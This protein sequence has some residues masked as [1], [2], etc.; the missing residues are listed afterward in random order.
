MILAGPSD[1]LILVLVGFFEPVDSDK[2]GKLGEVVKA[3]SSGFSIKELAWS[4]GSKVTGLTACLV[5][6]AGSGSTIVADSG[7]KAD[8]GGS[9]PFS[10][11]SSM[12]VRHFRKVVCVMM[13]LVE[14][15]QTCNEKDSPIS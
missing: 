12:Q 6:G 4:V 8:G 13:E 7:D 14:M 15:E 1:A 5:F 10:I 11:A 2:L 9:S 3:L